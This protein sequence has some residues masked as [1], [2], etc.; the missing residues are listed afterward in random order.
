MEV[1]EEET[2]DQIYEE[3]SVRQ[4]RLLNQIHNIRGQGHSSLF[5]KKLVFL[6]VNGFSF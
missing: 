5:L 6:V 1:L 3:S 4:Q 2:K